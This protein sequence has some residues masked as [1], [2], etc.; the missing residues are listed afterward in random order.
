MANGKNKGSAFERKFCKKLSLWWTQNDPNGPRDSVFWRTSNSGGRAT[1]RSQDGKTTKNQYGDICAIDPVGQPLLDLVVFELKKGYSKHTIADLLDKPDNGG[2]Q[3]YE[4]WIKQAEQSREQA[5]VPYWIIVHQRDRREP[6]VLVPQK[7]YS[8]L[9]LLGFDS[10]KFCHVP[11]F[12]LCIIEMESKDYMI[13]KLD[14]FLQQ[15][16]PE[17]IEGLL[18]KEKENHVS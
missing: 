15:M 18:K 14:G 2:D 13:C 11:N 10:L 8:W 16:A 6:V 3:E 1:V 7:L 5:G 4:K 9:I 12:V 17:A